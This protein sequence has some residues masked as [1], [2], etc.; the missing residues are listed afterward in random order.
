MITCKQCIETL[1]GDPRIRSGRYRLCGCDYCSKPSYYRELEEGKKETPEPEWTRRQWDKVEQ[2]R[3]AFL[4][5]QKQ[6]IELYKKLK[7][8]DADVYK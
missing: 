3:L 5:Q 1:L 6:Y 2:Y 7:E 4:H 8:E